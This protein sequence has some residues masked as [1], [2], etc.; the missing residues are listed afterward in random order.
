MRGTL[1]DIS[2]YNAQSYVDGMLDRTKYYFSGLELLALK[3]A[4]VAIIGVGASGSMVAELLARWG[5]KRFRLLDMDKYELSNINRQLF[6]TS[7]TIGRWKAEVAAERIKEINPFAEIE[8]LV[9]EKLTL[10]NAGPFIQGASIVVNASDTRSGF[11]LIHNVAHQY[12]IPVVEGHGWKMTGVKIRV[13]DYRDPR[14]IKY[15]E[16]FRWG[17]LNRLLAPFFDSSKSDFSTVTQEYVDGL[18]PVDESP[19]GSLGTTTTL[20]GCAL[21]T[22]A[23]KLLTGKGRTIRHPYETSLNLFSMRM[24]VAHKNSLFNIFNTLKKR[25]HEVLKN[26][27]KKPPEKH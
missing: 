4:T 20:V 16:P 2:N 15:N 1:V 3:N 21:A 11:Y 25:R 23:I 24:R 9:N 5:F 17:F 8:Y 7:K 14:Q 6:A 12:K 26:I 10:K 18:D 22:E 13:F 19:S 27:F